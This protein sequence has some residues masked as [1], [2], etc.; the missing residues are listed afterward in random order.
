M[1]TLS[2]RDRRRGFTLMELLIVII[3]IAVLAAIALPR[4]INSG[5]RSKEASLKSD[6]KIY[7]NAVQLFLN[8][9]GAYPASLAA[10][11][12][13][14][15]PAS[16][17]D[18]AG[19]SKSITSTDWKGPYIDSIMSDPVSGNAFTYGATSPNVGKVTSSA[20]GNATD[21]TAYSSW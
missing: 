3:V 12:A 4:F 17:I 14:S 2:L 1:R 18:S 9:T 6:L 10:L 5:L 7:R 15:A 19:A 16:G 11:S 20:S 21:G 13:T 8:D